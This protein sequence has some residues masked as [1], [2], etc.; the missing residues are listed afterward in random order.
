[1]S[2][3]PPLAV[4][5]FQ[6]RCSFVG[7]TSI[8]TRFTKNTFQFSMLSTIGVET[9]SKEISHNGKIINVKFW[10]TAGQERYSTISNQLIRKAEGIMFVYDIT[11]EE[12]FETIEEYIK[13]VLDYKGNICYILIGNKSDC[14]E[15]DREVSYNDGKAL[16]DAFKIDFFETSAL[17]GDNIKESCL[18]LVRHVINRNEKLKEF[19]IENNK[20]EEK[21][22]NNSNN[23]NDYANFSLETTVNFE[24]FDLDKK[25]GC[26]C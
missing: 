24:D 20:K 19:L 5:L 3:A 2:N 21:N 1:M 23:N 14:S 26:G 25:K 10:D 9:Y 22:D 12:T 8:A 4:S 11:K 16:A 17:N 15:E 18:T 7:K 13:N 6:I